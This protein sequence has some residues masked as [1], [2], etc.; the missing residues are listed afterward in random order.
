VIQTRTVA[1]HLRA[2]SE[3]ITMTVAQIVSFSRPIMA[4][5]APRRVYPKSETRSY[6]FTR[7]ASLLGILK[8]AWYNRG[9]LTRRNVR[10]FGSIPR[11]DR[12]G[13][14]ANSR[15]ATSRINRP[16]DNKAHMVE[17]RQHGPDS[18]PVPSPSSPASPPTLLMQALAQTPARILTGRVGAAYRTATWLK[19]R[20]DHAA[21]RDAVRSEVELTGDLG[22][23]F[24]A[25]WGLF[26]VATLA[27]T[28]AE[29]LLRPDLGRSLED[30]ARVELARR[31]PL[32]ADFQVA[33]ADGLSAVAVRAQVPVIL[34]LLAA[35]AQRR[36]W[37]FGQPFF[38]RHARVGTL[39]DIGE[40]LN[41]TVAVLLIGERP[42]L[43]TA[44]SLSA[45]MAYRPRAGHDDTR[46]NLIS[47]IHV[48]GVPP[49]Q[50]VPRIAQLAARMIQLRTSGV[51]VKEQWTPVE[52]GPTEGRLIGFKH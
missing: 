4:P 51:V 13:A 12:P 3:P 18:D 42:G 28:K 50:A 1:T 11:T 29:F 36:N 17:R 41:P 24:V 30:A 8:G 20:C 48:R 37:Q 5:P 9:W 21:A 6:D 26:E 47:N 32:G 33:I 10:F 14:P 52:S 38:I 19:L 25:E 22:T 45:Y 40:T 27:Q 43:A 44:E 7:R 31:C 16:M 49:E 46:R 34:P 15:H 39:N 23:V 35:E 2:W